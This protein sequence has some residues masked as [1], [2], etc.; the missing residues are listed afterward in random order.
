MQKI[1]ALTSNWLPQA[2]CLSRNDLKINNKLKT[3]VYFHAQIQLDK[4]RHGRGVP[5]PARLPHL[6]DGADVLGTRPGRHPGAT[7]AFHA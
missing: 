7:E 3:S 2:L 4:H 6:W 1:S 5:G